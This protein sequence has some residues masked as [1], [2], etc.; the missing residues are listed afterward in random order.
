MTQIVF[1]AEAPAANIERVYPEDLKQQIRKVGSLYPVPVG[2]HNFKDPE[3]AAVLREAEFAFST[4]GMPVFSEAEIRESMPMLKAVLYG[5]GTV[6]GFAR[7]FLAC[8]VQVASAWVA[9]G[10]PVAQYALAQILLANKGFYQSMS[11][12]KT[13][14]MRA[15]QFSGTFPGNYRVRV[16]LLGIGAIGT[17]VAELLMPFGFEVLAF[18]PFLSEEKAERLQVRKTSLEEIFG[19]CQ[20]IS[21][22][23]ANLPAT[24]GILNRTHFERMLPYATFINTGRGA[25]VVEPEL[26]AALTDVPTRTAVLD[27]TWPEPM[28]PDN[29]LF[30]LPNVFLTPH[31]AGSSGLE[32]VRMGEW[33]VQEL[34]RLVGGE[35]L[36]WGVTAKMLETMA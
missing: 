35:S 1:L 15:G 32:V 2:R 26:A 36:R 31:I 28:M 3:V 13:D 12:A 20:T 4:W 22:H 11:L 29:P 33:M 14:R 34:N 10:V 24:V 30:G 7:S 18:D 23:L 6:Q 5:A 17:M 27:V 8:G 21:N 9:N 16:G 25:Q 19:T